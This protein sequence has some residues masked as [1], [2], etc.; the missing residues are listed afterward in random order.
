[1]TSSQYELQLINRHSNGLSVA[2]GNG[3]QDAA[4][5]YVM[6]SSNNPAAYHWNNMSDRQFPYYSK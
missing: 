3:D 4:T 6:N 1:M 2:N 5:S